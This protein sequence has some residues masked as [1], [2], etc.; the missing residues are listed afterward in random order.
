MFLL[1]FL[2]FLLALLVWH[3]L[4]L[5]ASFS[6]T[7]SHPQLA[8]PR[9]PSP[10]GSF[11]QGGGAKGCSSV[12]RCFFLSE[13]HPTPPSFQNRF[14][15]K[16][17]LH[18]SRLSFLTHLLFSSS[19]PSLPISSVLFLFSLSFSRSTALLY[20][21]SFSLAFLSFVSC[22]LSYP[23]PSLVWCLGRESL[24]EQ[25]KF[26]SVLYSLVMFTFLLLLR[27]SCC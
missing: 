7:D 23:L 3:R 8:P 10:A 26:L 13:H 11:F 14:V 1:L 21:F 4:S 15:L 20:S 12:R 16:A 27:V 5:R 25:T 17:P 22:L 2:L 19:D 24:S 6:L 18:H 9:R